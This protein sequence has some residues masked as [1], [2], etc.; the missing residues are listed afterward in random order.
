MREN[1]SRSFEA[2]LKDEIKPHFHLAIMS[3][4]LSDLD[5]EWEIAFDLIDSI[6]G[7]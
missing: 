6:I 5:F 7:L 4:N 2:L 3:G 1:V